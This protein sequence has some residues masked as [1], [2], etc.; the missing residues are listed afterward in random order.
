MRPTSL[1][2]S[3]R[4]RRRCLTCSCQLWRLLLAKA[5]QGVVLQHLQ[6]QEAQ[7]GQIGLDQ[8]QEVA[9]VLASAPLNGHDVNLT[10]AKHSLHE[11]EQKVLQVFLLEV[12]AA[13][14]LASMLL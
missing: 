5:Q 9:V 13:L 10:N 11:K 7:G 12:P 1:Q 14:L 2:T 3:E 4:L 6:P 8:L